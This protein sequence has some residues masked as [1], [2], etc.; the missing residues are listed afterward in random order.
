MEKQVSSG[1]IKAIIAEGFGTIRIDEKGCFQQND[2]LNLFAD[3]YTE[4]ICVVILHV[5][6]LPER[7]QVLTVAVGGIAKPAK[8]RPT[9][10]LQA[11]VKG[12]FPVFKNGEFDQTDFLPAGVYLLK[13]VIIKNEQKDEVWYFVEKTDLGAPAI[14]WIT[15]PEID[16][17]FV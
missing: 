13:Q 1:K 15:N 16:L 17:D 8:V 14:Y 12:S 2:M 6:E 5:L 10:Q 9:R 11:T 7:K 3:E 4:R